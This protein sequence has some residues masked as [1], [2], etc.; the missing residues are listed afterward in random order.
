MVGVVPVLQQTPLAIIGE[1]PLE[2]IVPPLLAVLDVIFVT[3]DVVSTGIVA[4]V[5]TGT[6]A[7]GSPL[8]VQLLVNNKNAPIN[9]ME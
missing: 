3:S 1:P 7:V 8:L 5:D 6:G 2:I 4:V 9:S